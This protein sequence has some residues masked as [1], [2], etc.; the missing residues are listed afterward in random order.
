MTTTRLVL[1]ATVVL[2]VWA[3]DDDAL[4][5]RQRSALGEHPRSPVEQPAGNG[6]E[7][8]DDGPRVALDDG[9]V[10]ILR[11][12]PPD[13]ARVS[14]VQSR[15]TAQ[16]ASITALQG[17][18]TTQGSSIS[19]VDASLTAL[20]S[21]VDALEA[22]PLRPCPADMVTVGNFCIDRY[23]ATV[24]AAASCTGT[25]YGASSYDYP[26]G[27]SP[28][29][30]VT[31]TLYACSVPGVVPSASIS[32]FQAQQACAASGKRLCSN[33]EWQAAAAGTP[34]DTA[35]CNLDT[36]GTVGNTDARPAC[37][38]RFGAL[39]MVGN[40]WEWV[41]AWVSATGWN[42]Q[43]PIAGNQ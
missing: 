37:V 4:T 31:T 12:A 15:D 20:D 24:F 40:L 3:C 19:A 26:A 25:R 10:Y 43:D 41:T 33:D 36:A 14:A 23:E 28:N 35:S 32:W 1:V 38:S 42:G 6:I 18:A 34:D 17:T 2:G 30:N 39:N 22:G 16:G 9:D 11:G 8:R 21:R 13:P 27:F 29:G 7:R 5:G